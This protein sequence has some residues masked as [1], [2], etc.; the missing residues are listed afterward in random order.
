MCMCEQVC[1]EV[2]IHVCVRLCERVC[3]CVC[4]CVYVRPLARPLPAL[5]W[6][7]G[8]IWVQPLQVTLVVVTLMLL[9]TSF[10]L[11]SQAHR[12]TRSDVTQAHV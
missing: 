6:K 10:T 12:L 8:C 11:L 1:A 5:L 7:R 4:V 3:V 2:C 9:G